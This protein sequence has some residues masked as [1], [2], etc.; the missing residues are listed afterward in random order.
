[1]AAN[2]KFLIPMAHVAD[3]Q[4]SVDF[5]A[6]LG[7]EPL[8]IG[9]DPDG[10]CPWAHIRSGNAHL[11]FSRDPESTKVEKESTVV[12]YLYA[13]DLIKLREELVAKEVKVSEI[14]YPFYMPKGEVCLQDP[15]GYVILIGQSD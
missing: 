7:F 14:T 15:D 12:L 10:H 11:M 9:K 2:I 6:Q 1:M 13:D 4:R 5:Y 3:V 8:H